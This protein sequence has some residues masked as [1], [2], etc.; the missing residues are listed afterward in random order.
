MPRMSGARGSPMTCPLGQLEEIR[1]LSGGQTL[2]LSF[3]G[4]VVVDLDAADLWGECRSA[5]G[6]LRRLG[7]ANP[8]AGLIITALQPVGEYAVNIAFSDGEQRGIYPFSLLADL[9]ARQRSAAR[10]AA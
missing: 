7:G 8:P 9:S 3:S 10:D 6:V 1:R 2:R 5:D 4:G